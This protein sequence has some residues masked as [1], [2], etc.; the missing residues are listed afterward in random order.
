MAWNAVTKVDRP[1]KRTGSAVGVVAKSSEEASYS[2]NCDSEREGNRIQVSCRLVKTDVTLHQL[3]REES[4]GQR[5][6]N[7]FS[8]H[9]VSGIVEI[10][11]GAFRIFEPEKQFGSNRCPRYSD[12]YES[13][14]NRNRNRVSEAATDAQVGEESDD[15]GQCFKEQMWV[16]AS[17]PEIQII[18]K[19]KRGLE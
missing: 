16:D 15:V 9:Q 8:S 11:P 4:E 18:R 2:P 3:H 7:C 6:D 12:R 1:W 17:P 14:P 10:A 19:E 13:P 5:T